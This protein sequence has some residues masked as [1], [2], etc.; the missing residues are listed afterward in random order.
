MGEAPAWYLTLRAAKYLG[1]APWDLAERP[2]WWQEIALV[3][4]K[5]ETAAAN[6]RNKTKRGAE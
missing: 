2:V 4:E 1:V 5:A 3:A 6:S